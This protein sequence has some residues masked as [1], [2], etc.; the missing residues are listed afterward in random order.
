MRKTIGIFAHI[1]AGKTTFCEQVLYLG[2]AIRKTGRVDH[3]DSFFDT[4]QIERERGVTVFAHEGRFVFNGNEYC[5]ID[6]PG[7]ADFSAETER[8][9]GALDAAIILVDGTSGVRPQTKA[10]FR[11]LRKAGKPCFFFINKT[12]MESCDVEGTLSSMRLMLDEN[13]V[14][15]ESLSAI[16]G[17]DDALCEEVAMHDED[18]M[19]LYFEGNAD[20]ASLVASMQNL[21]GQGKVFPVLQGSALLGQGVE[22]CLRVLDLLTVT[23]YDASEPLCAR[24]F[25]V[26]CAEQL[27]AFLKVEQGTLRVRDAFTFEGN[28]E[29]IDEMNRMIAA[30]FGFDECFDVAGQTYP[31]KID[32]RILNALSSVAQSC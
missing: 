26:R 28:T 5:L 27:I 6:T 11:M 4:H 1:D 17:A 8:A 21:V 9:C 32:S 10:L 19:S 16:E 14:F 24:V 23:R 30:D 3:G 12:D 15:V 31:R 25:R 7:H 22:E 2:G 29:K 18:F 20:G 13:V